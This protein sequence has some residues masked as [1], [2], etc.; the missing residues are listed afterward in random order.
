MNWCGPATRSHGESLSLEAKLAPYEPAKRIFNLRM[1]R[2]WCGLSSAWIRVEV[3]VTSTPF[4]VTPTSYELLNKLF[5][6]HMVTV[7]SFCWI[8]AEG[9]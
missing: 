2:D 1:A 6:I 7:T 9:A 4:Q 5:P 3:V 8:S